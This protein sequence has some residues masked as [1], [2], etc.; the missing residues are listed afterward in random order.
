MRIEIVNDAVITKNGTSRK[1]G[2]AYTLRQ[3]EA[4]LV[5]GQY[6][7][8][9][10]VITLGR[11]QPGYPKGSYS[12]GPKS[13]KVTDFGDLTIGRLELVPLKGAQSGTGAGVRAAG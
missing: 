7:M 5:L 8:R 13:F 3:Q 10:L 4:V 12:I 6:D 11:E 2:Q 1:T 9:P